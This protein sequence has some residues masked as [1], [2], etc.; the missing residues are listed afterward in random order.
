MAP[1]A[2]NPDNAAKEVGAKP[3]AAAPAPKMLQGKAAAQAVANNPDEQRAAKARDDFARTFNQ[4]R[5]FPGADETPKATETP[6]APEA[7]KAPEPAAKQA[8]PP[9][10]SPAPVPSFQQSATPSSDMEDATKGAKKMDA[11]KSLKESVV[12]VGGNKYRIL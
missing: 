3:P 2:S 12:S 5:K 6:K 1:I 7:P 8:E 10:Q 9:T 4:T 11:I